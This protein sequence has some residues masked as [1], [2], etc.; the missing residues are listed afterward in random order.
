MGCFMGQS[1]TP[2]F[3]LSF[4]LTLPSLSCLK[5]TVNIHR[6]SSVNAWI[7]QAVLW[8]VLAAMITRWA[9]EIPLSINNISVSIMRWRNDKSEK[10]NLCHK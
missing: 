6:R 1:Q 7:V 5:L 4:D 3:S 8:Q 9:D 10:L 2:M